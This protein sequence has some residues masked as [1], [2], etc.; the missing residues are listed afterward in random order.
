MKVS[1]L[2]H[3]SLLLVTIVFSNQVARAQDVWLQSYSL[4]NSGCSKTNSEIVQ[5]S[6]LNNSASPMVFNSITASYSVDGG[7]VTSQLVG[8]TLPGNASI[9]LAFNVN[10]NLS[11]CGP[12]TMKVWV[13]RAGDPNQLNDTLTWIVQNDCPIVPGTILSNTNVCSGNNSGA[14]TLSGWSY[15]TITQWQSSTNGG[16]TWG[17]IT[18]TTT[19]FNYLNVNQVT[20]YR[21]FINGGLCPN[22]YSA[23]ATL[24][25][26]PP[27][28][29][30]TIAGSDSVC[31][32]NANGVL[33]ISGTTNN[34]LSW[35]SSI[36]NGGTWS[37]I[38]NTTYTNAYTG[39]TSTT[40]FRA[41]IDGNGCPNIYTDTAEI[42]V[43][44]LSDAGT[45]LGS[46]SLCASNGAGALVLSGSTG[47]VDYWEYSIDGT[48]WFNI[49]STSTILTYNSLTQT[50]FYRAH[51]VGAFC[52]SQYSDTAE[53]YIQ[54][55]PTP[56]DL[57]GGDSLCVTSVTGTVILTTP[58][59]SILYWEYSD[60][61]GS[62]WNTIANTTN[63][64]AFAGLTTTRL[65]RL[66]LDGGFCADYYSN[67][68]TVYVEQVTNPGTITGPDSLC[69]T[70]A[71]GTL[72][73][74]GTIGSVS[75]WQSS[76]NNGASWNTLPVT[77]STYNFPSLIQT[78]WFR[79][80]TDGGFCPS[81]F[82]DTAIVFVD[83]EVIG[84]TISGSGVFCNEALSGQLDIT[85]NN[86]S[87]IDWEYSINNGGSW[88]SSGTSATSLLY[89]NVTTTTLY[90]VLINGLICPDDYSDTATIQIDA[91][92]DAGI[93]AK[94]TTA[95]AGSSFTF[96]VLGANGTPTWETSS[97]GISWTTNSAATG[98]T[99]TILSAQTT[100]YNQ[101]IVTNGVCPPD[102][103]NSAV[104][105]IN[106]LPTVSA[107]SDT[108]IT[109]G[110]SVTI[111]GFGGVVGIWLPNT[112][113]SD[114]T[115]Q[116]PI[117]FPIT[118]TYYS[119]NVIGTNGCIASDSVLI[120]VK[121]P[122][123][124]DIKNVITANG[125]TYND[126]WIIE[127]VENYPNTEVHVFNIYGNEVF[128]DPDYSNDW[129]ATYKG[130]QLPNG[131]YF[132]VVR[133]EETEQE[134]K[135]SLTV[136]GDE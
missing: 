13:Q 57:D 73:I 16:S 31:I 30:G 46:D 61:A 32:T 40:L 98:N 2:F 12:H 102:T 5:V 91:F 44:V 78:T 107:L 59:S 50:T 26:V 86:S 119:Y 101:V 85:G 27:P 90:R 65:Y 95:C 76:T 22:A 132:Y 35:E 63:S 118:T 70:S 58:P 110:D 105:T 74:N 99:Y 112:T 29:Q 123:T 43:D 122:T 23:I 97:D 51:T 60:N 47:P 88:L 106:P 104:I 8:T 69:V 72:V 127:G 103:S 94:D 133:L 34:I 82:T 24:T 20:Q 37:P 83:D 53:I 121:P 131:T 3:I 135:G 80:Y 108:T 134:F 117:V 129:A 41:L 79:A 21:V 33:T 25:P 9:N 120:T 4:P 42:Y 18:N 17:P 62:S 71:T 96:E 100:E 114:N 130:K 45:V 48:N 39:L 93:L 77:T 11:A 115:V 7:P 125:D 81:Y 66:F 36:N 64:E 67:P 116:N 124:L 89:T 126:Y 128:S 113:I 28:V 1:K 75:Y 14:L 38:A 109:E 52:P 84:G 92:S 87:I 10:A 136:L 55:I 56:P 111:V 19:T 6:I 68:T 49:A 54:A 15:G